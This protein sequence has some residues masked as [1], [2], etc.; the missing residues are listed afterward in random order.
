MIVLDGPPE[1]GSYDVSPA[2]GRLIENS[3]WRPARS[4]YSGLEGS[5]TVK[6]IK[7]TK[8]IADCSIRNIIARTQ[9]PVYPLRGRYEF[10][11][12]SAN[13]VPLEECAIHMGK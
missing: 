1:P 7:G 10:D 13:D 6:A 2:N 5:I 4:P 12:M 9:D 11:I 8:L 3:S